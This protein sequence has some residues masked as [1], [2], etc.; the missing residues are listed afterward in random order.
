MATR[1]QMFLAVFVSLLTAHS[2]GQKADG[3]L[4]TRTF[5]LDSAM[6]RDYV[7]RRTLGPFEGSPP[8][9][10]QWLQMRFAR[11]GIEFPESP[12]AATLPTEKAMFLN[13]RTGELVVRASREDLEQIERMVAMMQK[14]PPMV[15]IEVRFLEAP[16]IEPAIPFRRLPR[17]FTN[18][19]VYTEKEFREAIRKF[20]RTRGVDI[21]TGP[22]VITISGRQARLVAEESRPI[23]YQDPPRLPRDTSPDADP[24]PRNKRR[25]PFPPGFVPTEGLVFGAMK[26][27]DRE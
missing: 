1:L 13:E 11:V 3:E 17:G 23:L 12:F 25:M 22:R 8:L 21:V 27:L 24:T 26:R 2:F 4:V 7:S 6:V 20:E 15:E 14:A 9:A 19:S 16:V 5:K 10:Q 18:T